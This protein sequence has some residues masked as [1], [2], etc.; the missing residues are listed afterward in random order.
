LPSFV[1]DLGGFEIR[2]TFAL[3][4]L[5]TRAQVSDAGRIVVD[6]AGGPAPR[7][8]HELFRWPGLYGL[9]LSAR[10]EGW[11]FT[12][13]A[14]GAVSV[15]AD[16]RT[17]SCHPETASSSDWP[18]LVVRRILPRVA[19]WHGRV[20]LHASTVTNGQSSIVLLG[21][22][23]AGKSTLAAAMRD[24]GWRVL[25]DDISLFDAD[26]I[27]A[28]AFAT[29]AGL[30]LWPDSL[31]AV[32]G[33]EGGGRRVAGH[34]A[35]RW[36]DEDNDAPEP[37]CRVDSL[38]LLEPR[39]DVPLSVDPVDSAAAAMCAG[40]QMVVFNPNDAGQ[41]SRAWAA[42]GRLVSMVPMCRCRYPR[43]YDRLDGLVDTLT[44]RIREQALART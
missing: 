11:L 20:A 33:T 15:S 14:H 17:I 43:G 21:P 3:P 1:Y 5:R 22:S 30:C 19:Q 34:V 16:G 39:D 8:S 23:Q 29:T 10:D 42:V 31:S 28:V 9:T 4:G 38:V 7:V 24:R 27:P 6:I 2:S 36:V 37:A 12:T 13:S 41:L 32:V 40:Q 25:S 44:R 35:K 26:G 18:D